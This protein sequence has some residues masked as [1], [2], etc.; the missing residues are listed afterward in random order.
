MSKLRDSKPEMEFHMI[1]IIYAARH[2]PYA[3]KHKRRHFHA[4]TTSAKLYIY[5]EVGS[6]DLFIDEADTVLDIFR[7]AV[8]IPCMLPSLLCGIFYFEDRQGSFGRMPKFLDVVVIFFL[9]FYF[10]TQNFFLIQNL[11]CTK[12]IFEP[13]IILTEFS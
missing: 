12:I 11:Y 3:Q 9:R 6:R 13:Q 2:C 1:N 7:F 4:K 8:F 10:L 5:I